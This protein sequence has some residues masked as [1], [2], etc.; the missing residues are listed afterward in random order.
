MRKCVLQASRTVWLGANTLSRPPI[1][2]LE[3]KHTNIFKVPE[4]PKEVVPEKAVSVA[5]PQKPEAPPARGSYS[6]GAVKRGNPGLAPFTMIIGLH[7]S[8]ILKILISFKRLKLLKKPS[9]K[10]PFPK[11]RKPHLSQVYVS[12][13]LILQKKYLLHS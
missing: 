10:R 9:R 7:C 8:C 13:G 4:A 3:L 2:S 6:H 11:S 12:P 1:Y 5:V